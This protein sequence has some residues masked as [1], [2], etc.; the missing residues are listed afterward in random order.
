MIYMSDINYR[1][2]PE[3]NMNDFFKQIKSYCN[4]LRKES[5]VPSRKI[6]DVDKRKIIIFEAD[7]N[8]I[9]FNLMNNQK[10]R[11]LLI[12]TDN[13]FIEIPKW[14]I[15]RKEATAIN[16]GGIFLSEMKE[17]NEHGLERKAIKA[18]S[19]WIIRNKITGNFNVKPISL[20][21]MD[22]IFLK[23][24]SLKEEETIKAG[25]TWKNLRLTGQIIE[26]LITDN[27]KMELAEKIKKILFFLLLKVEKREYTSYKKWTFHG[28]VKKDIIYSHEVSKHKR[29]FW[30]D[31]GRFKIPLMARDKWEEE[32]YGT[33]EMVFRDGELRKNVP[34]K[35]I[36][37]FFVGKEK[38]VK[39]SNRRIKLAKGRVLKSE[40]KVYEILKELFPN[41]YIKRHDRRTLNGLELD[42]NLPELRLGVE[43]DGE[44]H[45]DRKVCEE[46][47]KSDF[48][49]LIKRD[50]EKNKRCIKKN[51][52]LVRIKHDEPLTKYN[53]KK[54]LKEV[55]II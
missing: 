7:I 12:P 3:S 32:G 25:S 2:L 26:D 35:I 33:H 4:E 50:R 39:G 17:L 5:W 22:G 47:F 11:E 19:M 27:I 18:T 6:L 40:Q 31:S 20:L 51:I 14:F 30:K 41:N 21:F 55:N 13:I 36:G 42:F 44:Q 24:Y 29:H 10:P 15:D 37:N 49:A 46:V 8:K 53:I 38:K 1:D 23:D 52:T 16:C 43:Y 45:F 28:F 48:D 54:R 9:D 34:Y